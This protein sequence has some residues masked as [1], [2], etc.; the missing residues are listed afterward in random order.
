MFYQD[1]KLQYQVK[2]DNPNSVFVKALQQTIGG[3]EGKIRVC[4]Q[5]PFQA[6]RAV[7]R[8]TAICY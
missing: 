4:L 6:W 8:N 2:V 7:R 3:V 5:Y 1:G